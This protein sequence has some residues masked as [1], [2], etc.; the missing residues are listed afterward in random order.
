MTPTWAL[1]KPWEPLAAP[2]VATSDAR[3]AQEYTDICA[4]FD[5]AHNPRYLRGQQGAGETYCNIY[6][7][8]C[9]K[10]LGCEVPHWVGV[11]GK[12]GKM[13]PPS[14]ELDANAVIDWLRASK[15]WREV[16][17]SDAKARADLGFPVVVAYHAPPGRIGHV[18]ML[19]PGDLIAQ[20]GASNFFM[21]PVAAGFGG[22]PTQFFTHD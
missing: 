10:A 22:L 3:K 19:L 1:K 17:H 2:H 11:D 5:V 9:T 7:W 20:A 4:Q 15:E 16:L 12:P 13:G 14:R 21:K 8:D 18:A 6:V